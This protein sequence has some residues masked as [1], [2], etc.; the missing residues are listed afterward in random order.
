M[1][2][3]DGE[4]SDQYNNAHFSASRMVKE[5]T[6]KLYAAVPQSIKPRT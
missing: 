3:Q 5:Y 4:G 2:G 1:V 6:D